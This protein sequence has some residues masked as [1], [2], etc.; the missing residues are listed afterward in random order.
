MNFHHRHLV[1]AQRLVLIKVRLLDTTFVECN[2][3]AQGRTQSVNDCALHLLNDAGR[4]DS[5]AAIHGAHYTMDANLS[6]HDGNFGNLRVEAAEAIHG[7]YT[8]SSSCRQ[9]LAP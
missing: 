4:V 7:G 8:K 2:V 9:R 3:A 1:D 5:D 6:L